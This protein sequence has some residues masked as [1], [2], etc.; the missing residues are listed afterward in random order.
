MEEISRWQSVGFVEL[1]QVGTE[2]EGAGKGDAHHF[3]RVDGDGVG[4]VRAVHFV[5]VGWGEDGGSAPG[6]VDVHC[7]LL[8]C[9]L[10]FSIMK[11]GIKRSVEKGRLN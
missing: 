6:T 7:L 10:C 11:E 1:A 2:E 9:S 3:M 5:F 4:E 8:A